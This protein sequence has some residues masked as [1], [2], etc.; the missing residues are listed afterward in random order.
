M[1][2]K[3]LE[4]SHEI[5]SFLF[6]LSFVESLSNIFELNCCGCTVVWE[7]SEHRPSIHEYSSCEVLN[8]PINDNKEV[9][10]C[11]HVSAWFVFTYITNRLKLYVMTTK[12]VSYSCMF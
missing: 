5:L 8:G 2:F 3:V 7:S 6:F 1:I 9:C 10:D 4:S 11:S 12:I